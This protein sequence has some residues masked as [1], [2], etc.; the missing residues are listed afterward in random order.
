MMTDGTATPWNLWIGR[1]EDR[2]PRR[3]G[4]LAITLGLIVLLGAALTSRA[5]DPI[6]DALRP[7]EIAPAAGGVRDLPPEWRWAIEPVRYE[8]MFMKRR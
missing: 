3:W 4:N 5:A 1:T 7:P 8:R 6:Y 2:P